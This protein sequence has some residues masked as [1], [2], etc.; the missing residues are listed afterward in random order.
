MS[1]PL[2]IRSV[3]SLLSSMCSI[4]AIVSYGKQ[5]GYQALGLVDRNVLSGAMPFKKA[6]QQANI[7]PIYGLEFSLTYNERKHDMILYAKNDRGFR[8]LMGLSSFICTQ[9]LDSIDIDTLKEY[10]EEN[11]LCLLSDDMPLTSAIDRRENIED[12][13]RKQNEVF[14][15]YIVGLM[16][17]DIAINSKRDEYLKKI[18]DKNGICYIALNRTF[19]PDRDDVEAYQVLKCIRDKKLISDDDSVPESGRYFLNKEQYSELYGNK[20][21]DQ[22]DLLAE[23][24]TVSLTFSTQLPEYR[25]KLD[26]PSKQYL[27]S[28]CREGLKRRLRNEIPEEYQKR[29][30]HE[31][32]IILDMHFEDYFLIVYD[33]ILYAKKNDILVGPGR[34]SAAG[35]LVSYCLGITDIDPLKYGLIFER[36][37]NPERISMPDID[38]DFPDDK[39][40]QIIAYVRDRYGA[41]HVAHIITFGTLKARQVLRD[42]GRVLNYTTRDIDDICKLIPNMNDMDLEKAYQTIPLFKQKIESEEKYR[43]LY[44][45][46]LKLEKNPR[47]ESTHAAGVVFSRKKLTEVVPITSIESDI[48]STQYTMEHLEELG[49]IKM[50]LLAIRNLTII[51]EIVDD[52]RKDT[53]FRIQDIPLD[54]DKTFRLIDNVNT[55][56]IFQLESAGMRNLIRKMKPDNFA[57]IGVAIALFRPGPMKNIPTFLENRAHPEKIEYPHPSLTGI[58]EETYG[59]IVYQ[60]QIMDIARKMAGFTYGKADIL[61]KAMAKKNASELQK[62]YPDFINGCLKNGY[63]RQVSERIYALIQEF[64]N[65]GF[66]K[67]HSIAYALVAYQLAY[68]KANY[69]LSFYKALLNGVIGSQSKT[70]DYVNECTNIGNKVLGPSINLS[71]SKYMIKDNAIIMP[72]SICKDVGSISV[73]KIISSRENEGPYKDYLDAVCR[74]SRASVDRNVIEN[75]IYAGAFDEFGL[76]RNTMIRNLN[77]VIMYANAHKNEML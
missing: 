77:N 55:L 28:L 12:E 44:Q 22:T 15:P 33:F 18:L 62:L 68:L 57:E 46:A 67:S 9:K 58:L 7:K 27:V 32:K 60:E 64:A 69:P 59:I 26:V 5:N 13:L 1:C 40:D 54:D 21:L 75:L 6:C 76:S 42:V 48:Y 2:Y 38:T 36:F 34:G 37:L 74:L 45:L 41:D 51:S 70:Y 19:Y 50:D 43:H 20:E 10:H 65:Y 29:L 73:S 25:N 11:V 14:A 31:L 30:E 71:S 47:H 24:C 39:R 3:Y 53:P 8:N 23:N 63:S 61:R 17:H 72:L 4:E 16:D 35:S 66:N 49:L 52:I 56:G